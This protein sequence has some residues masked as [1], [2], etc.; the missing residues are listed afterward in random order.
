MGRNIRIQSND[1]FFLF[2]GFLSKFNFYPPS[3][4]IA[5]KAEAKV[6]DLSFQATFSIFSK[7][8]IVNELPDIEK[9]F[10]SKYVHLI[11]IRRL[12]LYTYELR[13]EC[14]AIK[15]NMV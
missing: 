10:V 9:D 7:D 1:T 15:Q 8:I 5:L 3:P 11:E 4:D 14:R 6:V 13:G 2:C 12:I